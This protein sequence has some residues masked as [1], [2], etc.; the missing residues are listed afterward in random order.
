M[1]LYP[2]VPSVSLD[3]PPVMAVRQIPRPDINLVHVLTNWPGN[4]SYSCTIFSV[5]IAMTALC[6]QPGRARRFPEIM[7]LPEAIRIHTVGTRVPYQVLY[8]DTKLPLNLVPVREQPTRFS[9]LCG[10]PFY[11]RNSCVHKMRSHVRS[12]WRSR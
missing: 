2:S 7:D 12:T 3:L 8:P 11:S 1:L 5:G 10:G 9:C 4:F 6:T